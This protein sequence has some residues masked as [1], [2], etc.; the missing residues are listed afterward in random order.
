MVHSSVKVFRVF[1]M[2]IANLGIKNPSLVF[3]VLWEVF[4]QLDN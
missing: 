2:G 4:L 3:S 1:F